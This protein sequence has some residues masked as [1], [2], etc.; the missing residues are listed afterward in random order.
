MKCH[1]CKKEFEELTYLSIYSR[2][3]FNTKDEK[4]YCDLDFEEKYGKRLYERKL[5]EESNNKKS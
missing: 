4:G 1:K 2:G 3:Y 5:N